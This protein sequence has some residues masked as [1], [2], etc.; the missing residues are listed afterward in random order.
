MVKGLPGIDRLRID[1]KA[2]LLLWKALLLFRKPELM[3]D[4]IDEIGGV[5]A[6]M[7]SEGGIKAGGM[8]KLAKQTCT[9]RMKSAGPADGGAGVSAGG[10]MCG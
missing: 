1:G 7:D 5:F 6:I 3:P 10:R 2:G 8:C 9:D 4:E